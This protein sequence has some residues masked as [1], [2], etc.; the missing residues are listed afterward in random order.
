MKRRLVIWLHSIWPGVYNV[1][2]L[3]ITPLKS[4][5]ISSEPCAHLEL[6]ETK[7]IT[8]L[9]RLKAHP[10]S[11]NWRILIQEIRYIF[12]FSPY[13]FSNIN[14][15]FLSNINWSQFLLQFISVMFFFFL[16]IDIML[17]IV[18]QLLNVVL[19]LH[20]IILRITLLHLMYYTKHRF[21]LIVLFTSFSSFFFVD[22]YHLSRWKLLIKHVLY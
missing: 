15:G 7:N 19:N 12:H 17:R 5:L 1:I 11:S 22:V 16:Y 13:N 3:N 21:N 20:V 18:L 14:T 9:L 10:Q 8:H 2:S 6:K 4:F